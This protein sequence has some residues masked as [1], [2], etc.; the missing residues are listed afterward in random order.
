MA[1]PKPS[2]FQ[3]RDNRRDSEIPEQPLPLD[4]NY[5][6]VGRNENPIFPDEYVLET[7]TGLVPQTT[8]EQVRSPATAQAPRHDEDK[9]KALLGPILRLF[10]RV[11]VFLKK[12]L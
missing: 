11:Q 7:S 8:L 10:A 4:I 12:K 1:E 9:V 3:P 5:P 6:Y 2:E